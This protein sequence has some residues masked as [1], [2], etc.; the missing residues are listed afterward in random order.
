MDSLK[1]KNI[2]MR[3]L[4]LMKMVN[5]IKKYWKLLV[6]IFVVFHFVAYFAVYIVW[7]FTI[8]HKKE[9]VKKMYTSLK[10]NERIYCYIINDG[11]LSPAYYVNDS[12]S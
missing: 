7:P 3:R 11:S 4:K 8:N 10:N 1:Q 5:S 9:E 12:I 2:R 6:L